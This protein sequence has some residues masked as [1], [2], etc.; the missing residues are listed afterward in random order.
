MWHDSPSWSRAYHPEGV[1]RGDSRGVS[2]ALCTDGVN[3]FSHQR[4]TYMWPI[5]LTNLN[6]PRNVRSKFSNILLVGIIPGNGTKEPKTL[7]PYLEVVVDKLLTLTDF[8][9]FDAYRGAP[10]KLKAELLMYTL[11]Y[12]GI[13]K[14]FCVS[15]EGAYSGCVWCEI[16]GKPCAL[17]NTVNDFA[18]RLLQQRPSENGVFT[19]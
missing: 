10:F 15:G 13:N 16:K 5:M 4:V 11:D 14:V 1:F 9:T 12:P 18:C 7:S 3:P 2:L 17:M 19:E 6:L 8:K